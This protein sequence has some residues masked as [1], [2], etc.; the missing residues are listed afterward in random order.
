MRSP[1]AQLSA[2][3][4][5][6]G[7]E[8]S[9]AL[10]SALIAIPQS[11]VV[12]MLAVVPLGPSYAYL[13]VLAGLYASII[14][15]FITAL[16]RTGTCQVSGPHS[17]LSII[18]ASVIAGLM[19]DPRLA[20]PAGP[21][22]ARVLG[23]VF[24]CLILAG[25]IQTLLGMLRFGNFVKYIP[26]P[27]VAGFMNGI[28]LSVFLAQLHPLFGVP[29]TVMWFDGVGAWWDA[30]KPYGLLIGVFTLLSIRTASRVV[31]F[32]PPILA[33]LLL[34][35]L[36]YYVARSL[37]GEPAVGG[38]IGDIPS[39]LPG[40]EQLQ[41]L[42]A[43]SWDKTF[44]AL[45]V[46]LVPSALLIAVVSSIVSLM[47]SVSVAT[48]TNTRPNNN[49]ELLMQGLSNMANAA[50]GVAPSAGA[51]SR[52]IANFKAGG[53]TRVST[54]IHSIL[55]LAAVTSL[56]YVPWAGYIPAVVMAALLVNTAFSAVDSW[57]REILQRL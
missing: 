53:R 19:A 33:G 41:R 55:L 57:G 24:V 47:S 56:A 52:S 29:A 34:G 18:T 12:G 17:A 40:P 28:A 3:F 46:E 45:A 43:I 42:L 39:R 37:L 9:G 22:I 6:L 14:A 4:P 2:R 38:A 13:G 32:V 30:F 20:G 25:L 1:W 15:S 51:G 27:V 31:K 11:V 26:Y 5:N 23:L 50:F 54:L 48:L 10:S 16:P 36:M 8:F 7:G 44:I 49:T 35:T 21:D